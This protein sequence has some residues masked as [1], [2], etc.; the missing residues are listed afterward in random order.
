L[1]DGCYAYAECACFF[2]RDVL[3]HLA[4]YITLHYG[5]FSEAAIFFFHGVYTVCES[6]DT[7][8]RLEIFG[9]VGAHLN[10]GTH[11]VT[12]DGTAFALPGEGVKVD[13]PPVRWGFQ[14]VNHDTLPLP[15]SQLTSQ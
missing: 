2:I 14:F 7:V 4:L 15:R 5:I 13:V 6:S 1:S 9:D 11:V 3:W 10:D 12:A 8:T